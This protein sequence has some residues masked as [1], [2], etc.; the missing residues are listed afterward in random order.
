[1]QVQFTIGLD[2]QVTSTKIAS[3]TLGSP[4]VEDCILR[5][6]ARMQFPRPRGGEVTIKYPLIFKE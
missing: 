2:G 4:T 6:F 1:M 3:T 5:R